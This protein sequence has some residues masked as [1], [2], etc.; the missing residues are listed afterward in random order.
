MPEVVNSHVFKVYPLAD[1]LP[2]ALK[3]G[4]VRAGELAGDHPG[5]DT[6]ANRAAL[7]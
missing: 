6:L 5:I 1:A 7:A 4:E 3:V 2:R